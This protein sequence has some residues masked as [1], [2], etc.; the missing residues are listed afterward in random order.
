MCI[1]RRLIFVAQKFQKKTKNK[2]TTRA[3]IPGRIK[4]AALLNQN[5]IGDGW[6]ATYGVVG[7]LQIASNTTKVCQKVMKQIR[8]VALRNYSFHLDSL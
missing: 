4:A 1:L 2:Q 6:P 5:R 7:Y 8:I 3:L